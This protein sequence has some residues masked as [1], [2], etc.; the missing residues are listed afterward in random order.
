MLMYT[1]GLICVGKDHQQDMSELH[2]DADARRAPGTCMCSIERA[3][4]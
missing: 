3:L 2:I 1:T 4:V